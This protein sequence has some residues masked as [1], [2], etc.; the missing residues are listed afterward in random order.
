MDPYSP[1]PSSPTP[2]EYGAVGAKQPSIIEV[3]KRFNAEDKCVKHLGRIH[4]PKG[5]ECPR[6]EG[7]RI[8][9]FQA[10]G[11]TGKARHLCGCVDRSYQFSVTVGTIFHNSPADLPPIA[12]PLLM[13]LPAA[14]D[15]WPEGRA[16]QDPEAMVRWPRAPSA[17]GRAGPRPPMACR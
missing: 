16:E 2:R 14:L 12:L 7:Q 4:W 6:R 3:F 1:Q 5:V 15:P 13:G 9:Q 17:P 10:K 11:K 8:S